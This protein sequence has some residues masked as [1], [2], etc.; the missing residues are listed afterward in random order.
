MTCERQVICVR[1]LHRQELTQGRWGVVFL[2]V[3]Q[4]T[5]STAPLAHSERPQGAQPL[6]A[7][8]ERPGWAARALTCNRRTR[9]FRTPL[10]IVGA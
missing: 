3:G 1:Y 2:Q 4:R 10:A 6:D 8:R 5:G 7:K 9:Q